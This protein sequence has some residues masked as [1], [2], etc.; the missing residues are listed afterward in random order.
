MGQY[1]CK[2]FT[3]FVKS[4]NKWQIQFSCLALILHLLVS[5]SR[6]IMVYYRLPSVLG[7]CWL[8][9]KEWALPDNAETNVVPTKSDSDVCFVYNC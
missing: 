9:K 1:K 8:N 3:I 4:Q 2:Y 7:V 5:A 6:I